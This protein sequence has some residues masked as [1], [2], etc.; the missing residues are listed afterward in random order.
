MII[1]QEAG[2]NPVGRTRCGR[3]DA[4]KIAEDLIRGHPF[5]SF[6]Q[7]VEYSFVQIL[8]IL[9]FAIGIDEQHARLLFLFYQLLEARLSKLGR[10]LAL[11][12]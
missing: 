11:N 7:I 2:Q 3:T 9:L 6:P 8:E 1:F 4:E 12:E 5:P 10:V